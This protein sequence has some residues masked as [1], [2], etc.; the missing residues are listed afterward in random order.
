MDQRKVIGE[1]IKAARKARGLSQRALAE[2]LGIAFQNL[3]VW[4]NGKGAPS[5]RYLMKLSEILQISLDKLTSPNAIPTSGILAPQEEAVSKSSME[6][7]ESMLLE[8]K[9]EIPA[10]IVKE[11][12]SGH[13]LKLIVKYLEEIMQTLKGASYSPAAPPPNKQGS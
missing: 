8:I 12:Q 4:E 13:T 10:E 9:D 11:L 3:S 7:L 1:N 2:K 5:A 6:K